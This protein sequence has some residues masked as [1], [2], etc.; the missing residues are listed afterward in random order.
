MRVIA[1]IDQREVVEKIPR[2]LAS[3][4][5]RRCWPQPAPRPTRTGPWTYEPC[6]D[7]DPMPDYDNVL[8]D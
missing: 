2:H 8:T 6:L 4:V 1:V 5:A 3:G 7:G